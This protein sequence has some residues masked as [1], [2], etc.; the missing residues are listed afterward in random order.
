MKVLVTGGAGFIGGR[1]VCKLVEEG[2]EV[3]VL[4]RSTQPR[5][6][7]VTF[8]KVDLARTS[9]PAEACEGAEALFHI[10]AKAGV[11]GSV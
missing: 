8:H 1:I 4:G 3:H 2:H 11:W 5:E 10:A 9:I 6:D 7:T